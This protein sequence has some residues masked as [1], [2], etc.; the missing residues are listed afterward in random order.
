[1]AL[2]LA[3]PKKGDD[4]VEPARCDVAQHGFVTNALRQT[5]LNSKVVAQDGDIV[6]IDTGEGVMVRR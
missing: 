5:E 2:D 1:M 4:E 3:S 6:Q